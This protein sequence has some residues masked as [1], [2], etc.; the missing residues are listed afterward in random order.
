V[1]LKGGHS[2]RL[3]AEGAELKCILRANRLSLFSLN[4]KPQGLR[5]IPGPAT[6]QNHPRPTAQRLIGNDPSVGAANRPLHN[7]QRLGR[8]FAA[9]YNVELHERLPS[10][11][12]LHGPR[13][14]PS[15]IPTIHA[16]PNLS[17][18]MPNICDQMSRC[19]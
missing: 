17:V 14:V 1:R 9:I 7:Q 5:F 19:S 11:R 12:S 3:R 13:L 8:Y 4:S 2:G 6:S 18:H 10:R 15:G 16:T